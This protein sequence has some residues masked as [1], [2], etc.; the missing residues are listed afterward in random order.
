MERLSVIVPVLNEA[1]R[2]G[3]ALDALAPLRQ[4]GHEVIVV[5]GGSRDGSADLARI[6]ADK[7]LGSP[8]GR[9]TTRAVACS[10][11]ALRPPAMTW[12]ALP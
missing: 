10:R 3:A 1:A 9:A 5:D 2:I 4:R 6:R 11:N 8:R 12:P 7:V